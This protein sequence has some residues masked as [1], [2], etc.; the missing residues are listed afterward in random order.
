MSYFHLKKLMDKLDG[1]SLHTLHYYRSQGIPT[2]AF[3]EF[4]RILDTHGVQLMLD[5]QLNN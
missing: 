5:E 2:H 1:Q 4:C 3:S